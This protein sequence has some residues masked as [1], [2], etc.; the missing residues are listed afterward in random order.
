MSFFFVKAR[1]SRAVELIKEKLSDQCWD[2]VLSNIQ[3]G[4]CE[5]W[6]ISVLCCGCW[7]SWKEPFF[8]STK[9]L[10]KED[11]QRIFTAACFNAVFNL[12]TFHC[13]KFKM[14]NLLELITFVPH[15]IGFLIVHSLST[16]W[17]QCSLQLT[18]FF[19]CNSKCA[20][21]NDVHEKRFQHIY[22]NNLSNKF[23]N[24]MKLFF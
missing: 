2:H 20:S 13:S 8:M 9:K 12:K 1:F 17:I 18:I 3:W 11:Y 23:F 15:E 24:F 4:T 5:S 16:E 22:Y 21:T 14:I 10:F 6:A 19:I 7:F